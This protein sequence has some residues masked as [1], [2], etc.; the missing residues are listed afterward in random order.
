MHNGCDVPEGSL[1]FV[2]I[3]TVG[4]VYEGE[5]G[6]RRNVNNDKIEDEMTKR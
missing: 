1:W 4:M 5:G 2:C 3:L 6:G